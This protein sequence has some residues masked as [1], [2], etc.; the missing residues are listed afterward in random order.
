M[1]ISDLNEI[2]LSPEDVYDCALGANS[3]LSLD[4]MKR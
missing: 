2:G 3:H 4:F 1:P